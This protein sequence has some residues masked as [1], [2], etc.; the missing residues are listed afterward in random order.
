MMIGNFVFISENPG[1]A[2]VAVY[3]KDRMVF[4]S[5]MTETALVTPVMIGSDLT[6]RF[7]EGS[8]VIGVWLPHEQRLEDYNANT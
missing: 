1:A 7:T 5:G 4:S 8:G 2:K 6:P 3:A